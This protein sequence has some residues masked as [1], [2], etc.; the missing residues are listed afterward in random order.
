M[1]NILKKQI[2]LCQL[3]CQ[4]AQRVWPNDWQICWQKMWV[5]EFLAGWLPVAGRWSWSPEAALDT[6]GSYLSLNLPAEVIQLIITS[7]IISTSTIYTVSISTIPIST[8]STSTRSISTISQSPRRGDTN[9]YPPPPLS[10]NPAIICCE[11]YS[12]LSTRSCPPSHWTKASSLT[13]SFLQKHWHWTTC[14][15]GFWGDCQWC[16]QWKQCSV[17][18]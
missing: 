8:I 10:F 12:S 6:Q 13:L 16:Q 7:N 15:F 3:S 5:A 4:F 14:G 1:A 9:D 2:N 17:Y 18:N 11:K